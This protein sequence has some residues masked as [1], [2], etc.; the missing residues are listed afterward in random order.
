MLKP[1]KLV[2][3]LSKKKHFITIQDAFLVRLVRLESVFACSG[4]GF[5]AFGY[6]DDQE[7]KIE[8]T[9]YFI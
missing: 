5:I 9:F 7:Q 3:E 8:P 4:Y 6:I 1:I 2:T